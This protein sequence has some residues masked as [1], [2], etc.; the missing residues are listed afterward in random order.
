MAATSFLILDGTIPKG[1]YHNQNN[2]VNEHNM[3]SDETFLTFCSPLLIHF[4]E[5]ALL[6]QTRLHINSWADFCICAN[7]HDMIHILLLT[8]MDD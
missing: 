2:R 3:I 1:T 7:L 6:E 4:L 5:I 8:E